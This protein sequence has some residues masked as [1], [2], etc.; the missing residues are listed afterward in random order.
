MRAAI[1]NLPP[2]GIVDYIKN[3]NELDVIESFSVGVGS[4]NKVS[5]P[6]DGFVIASFSRGDYQSSN[7]RPEILVNNI[8]FCIGSSDSTATYSQGRGCTTIPVNAGDE[9]Y[10]TQNQGVSTYGRWYKKR[11]RYSNQLNT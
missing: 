3:Y 9:I 2:E 6:Y 8:V 10:L 5:A 1:G 11:A 4:A 7:I